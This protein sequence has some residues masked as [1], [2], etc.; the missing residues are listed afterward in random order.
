MDPNELSE[1]EAILGTVKTVV[2]TLT[3][4]RAAIKAAIDATNAELEQGKA[5]L[6]AAK[7]RLSSSEAAAALNGA[8][9]SK[10]DISAV[11]TVRDRLDVLE[12]RLDGLKAGLVEGAEELLKLEQQA[13]WAFR[14][15]SANWMETF[16]SEQRTAAVAYLQV[17]R[18]GMDVASALGQRLHSAESIVFQL[19]GGE[20]LGVSSPVITT[21]GDPVAAEKRDWAIATSAAVKA[22][23][24]ICDTIRPEAPERACIPPTVNGV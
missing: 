18:R 21:G 13:Q 8:A 14:I 6:D 17:V 2:A 12:A 16:A 7:R 11:R 15:V 4:K 5:D 1:A 24:G 9:S 10:A 20:L 22:L 3:E 23:G 19:T